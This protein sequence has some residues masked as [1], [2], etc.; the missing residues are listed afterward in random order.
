MIVK[1]ATCLACSLVAGVTALAQIP[2]RDSRNTE[3]RHTDTRYSLRAYTRAEWQDRAADLRKRILFS[4][5]LLPLPG[6]EPL[7]PRMGPVTSHRDYSVASVLLETY[8]GFFL[9]GN[10]YRPVGTPG[11]HPAVVSPHGHWRYGRFE[12][13]EINSVPGRAI[14]LARQ[15][16]IVFAHDMIGWN[17]TMQAPHAFA[18]PREELWLL[19]T[20]GLQLWNSIRVVDYL[21]SL[22]DVDSSRIGVTGASGGGTQAFLL[23]AVD[24]RVGYSAPVNMVSF[25]MQ[26][27]SPCENAPLLRIG[28]NN[29]EFAAAFAPKPQL[30][31]S[32][33]GDWTVNVPSEEFPALQRIYR[34]LD[35]ESYV[36]SRQFDSPHNYHKDSREAV[37]AFF[38]KHILGEVDPSRF[39]EDSSRPE[40]LSSL[41]YLWGR[42]L[43]EGAV[44]FDELLRQR[45][46]DAEAD[47]LELAVRDHRS[48]ERAR[49]AFGERLRLA[50]LAEVPR[51]GDTTVQPIEG[52]ELLIGRKDVGD[53]VPARFLNADSTKAPPMIL[54][55][56]DGIAAAERSEI[57]LAVAGRGWPVLMID[58]FQT[59]GAVE[60]RDIAGA[61]RNSERYYHVFNRSDD[62]NRVQDILTAAAFLRERGNADGIRLVGIGRAGL[63]A[64]LAGALDPDLRSISAD[65]DGFDAA[66]DTEYVE[67][68]FI[69]GLRRAGDFRAVA[70]L[71][72]DRDLLLYNAHDGFP[73][74]WYRAAFGAAGRSDGLRIEQG[75]A[76]AELLLEWLSR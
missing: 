50:L 43:P 67:G 75:A 73:L 56:A 3:I 2:D 40:Q 6:K 28:T 52:P 32:A 76:S 13:S 22:D 7:N 8:P 36:E 59:G 60:D 25:Q 54:V 38:G 53:R 37:Y 4:S 51:P 26:G 18:G 72:S 39:K 42:S 49:A 12:N 23:A 15:G 29:V 14:S 55:H 10:L 16:Y 61:G 64:L 9:G 1:L 66:T 5:G 62:A 58:A 71:L 48:L 57:G 45:I 27:G 30:L 21:V 33:T 24:D 35:A 69:P 65:A 44:G 17:D 74:A 63:W 19:G 46:A 20:L 68:L 34:L 11:P 47:T 70:P 41:L 31:V